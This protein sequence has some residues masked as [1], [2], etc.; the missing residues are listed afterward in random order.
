MLHASLNR[1][2]PIHVALVYGVALVLL[3]A[4]HAA[5]LYNGNLSGFICVGDRFIGR[6]ELPSRI[7]QIPNSAGYDGQFF[8]FMAHDPL[9]LGDWRR[10][11]DRP[12]YRYQR[13]LYPAVAGALAAGRTK[14]IPRALVIVNVVALTLGVWLMAS[15]MAAG[16]R[17]PWTGALIGLL[18]GCLLGLCRDLCDP[19]AVVLVTASFI[20]FDRGK[21]GWACVLLSAALLT[22]ETAAIALAMLLADSLVRRRFRDAA[23]VALSAAPFI[24]WTAYVWAQIGEPPWRGGTGNFG[25]PFA[26]MLKYA[27]QLLKGGSA[28]DRTFFAL[29]V[30]QALACLPI[31]AVHLWKRRDAMAAAFAVFAVM[32]FLMSRHVWVEP[33]SY[34]RV[35]VAGGAFLL[36]CHARTDGRATWVPL[37][38]NVALLPVTL[39]YVH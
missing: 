17:S 37:A 26:A 2:R 6:S 7:M 39:L 16:G 8:F 14:W 10:H 11:I 27:G 13:I 18:P 15:Y 34:A 28:V 35:L 20:F 4:V 9:I 23:M 3:V 38:I 33:W 19:M 21:V 32:P 31:A 24:A 36:L 12:A 30:A 22:R 1:V 25:A 29:F 5:R